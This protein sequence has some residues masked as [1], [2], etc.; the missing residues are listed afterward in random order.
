MDQ[1]VGTNAQNA[2]LA[3]SQLVRESLKRTGT[4]EV[5]MAE[6][7]FAASVHIRGNAEMFQP[8]GSYILIKGSEDRFVQLLDDNGQPIDVSGKR[9]ALG[10]SAKDIGD[11]MG[12]RQLEVISLA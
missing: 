9:C 7:P 8:I 4:A 3:M 1:V 11:Y 5:R 6:V 10:L 2:E 12:E